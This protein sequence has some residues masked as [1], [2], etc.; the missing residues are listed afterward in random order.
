MAAKLASLG[1]D[2][3]AAEDEELPDDDD[4]A[5][6]DG[7]AARESE[8]AVRASARA[9]S[10]AASARAAGQSAGAAG[11]SA[12]TPE[13]P[14]AAPAGFPSHLVRAMENPTVRSPEAMPAPPPDEGR[15][16]P[17]PAPGAMVA[18]NVPPA[19]APAG[20]ARTALSM[21][22][23]SSGRAPGAQQPSARPEAQPAARPP[24]VLKTQEL[25]AMSSPPVPT[26]PRGDDAGER[27]RAPAA[28]PAGATGGPAGPPFPALTMAQYASFLV[29][30]RL[31]PKQAPQ[32]LER[33][34][35]R[36]KT[37]WMDMMAA[38][39]TRFDQSPGERA[40]FKKLM[41][42]YEARLRRSG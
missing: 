21:Q 29:E 35:V 20:L 19:P 26:A 37:A 32:I 36:D 30:M 4:D 12:S 11:Q 41:A 14:S 15:A 34:Y 10:A 9:A 24:R 3:W 16:S 5:Y 22:D 1:P 27:A 8:E 25:P 33:Y 17:P 7:E 42:E 28:P 13:L 2:D 38:W 31:W 18:G 23:S 6:D 39:E 40:I